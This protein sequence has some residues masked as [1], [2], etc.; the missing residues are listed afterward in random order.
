MA[1]KTQALTLKRLVNVPPAEVYRAFT[2]ATALRDWLCDAA[3]V[4]AR[5]DGRLYV[6]WSSGAFAAGAFAG[7]APGRKIVF[8]WRHS[9][10]PEPATIRVALSARGSGTQVTLTH[11]AGSGAKWEPAL[12]EA[13]SAWESA[14]ENLQSVLE[15]GI[16]LRLARL[17]RM[18]IGI[19]DF[20]AE[21]AARLGVPVKAGVRLAGV[22]DGTGAQAAVLEKDDVLVSMSGKKLTGFAS[23][24]PALQGRQ[25]GDV[26]PVVF[27][28]GAQKH[29]VKMTLSKRPLPEIPATAADLAQIVRKNYADLDAAWDHLLDGVTE[30]EASRRP[31]PDEWS[32]KESLAHFALVERDT[33]SWFA[34]MVND[35]EIGESLEFRTNV[36]ARVRALVEVRPA[37][38][39]L[40]DEL[41][42]CERETAALLAGLP[43]S[44]VARRHLFARVS[45]WMTQ[46]IP[47]HYHDEHL[48]LM[49]AAIRSAQEKT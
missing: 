40:L 42:R 44:F 23:L 10:E 11:V 24:G 37:L 4:D 17:P 32:L 27:Y 45:G 34:Q 29:T 39:E 21:I 38:G 5:K 14:L 49:Q 13:Q 20:N 8:D 48:P 1:S 19:D 7:L 22:A 31:A 18:G 15:T 16:D 33:Q 41:R 28:R 30:E 12:A 47:S 2:N 9:R 25:A 3:E 43:D 26:V 6:W 46:V 36:D 35:G